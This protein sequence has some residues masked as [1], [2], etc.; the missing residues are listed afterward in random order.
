MRKIRYSWAM[1]LDGYI[2]GTGD[3]FDWI[4]MDP[5]IDF[6]AMSEQF[7]TYPAR[8]ANI[9]SDWWSRIPCLFEYP[10]V[11]VFAT[12]AAERLRPRHNRRRE[13][14]GNSSVASRRIGKG[15]LALRGR[16]T[17]PQSR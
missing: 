5:D 4:V 12:V 10:N 13:L 7:D 3:E 15:R 14:E 16:L 8:P 9:R 1:S 11:R 6:Q 17:V 2:A